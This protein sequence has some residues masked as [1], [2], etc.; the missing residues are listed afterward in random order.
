M[1]QLYVSGAYTDFLYFRNFNFVDG[2]ASE[3]PEAMIA[4]NS[5]WY[6]V[7]NNFWSS[8]STV[9][10]TATRNLVYNLLIGWYLADMFPEALVAVGGNGGMPLVVKSIGGVNIEYLQYK[11][12]DEMKVLTTNT[13]GLRA[14]TMI[15][16]APER[17]GML[18][19]S[20]GIFAQHDIGVPTLPV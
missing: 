17:F 18:G 20:K 11:I 10:Q 13:F 4:V 19:S 8:Q 6:G 9:Q 3:V 15:L 5:Q 14:L 7:L 1:A 2:G 16:S 12:Q